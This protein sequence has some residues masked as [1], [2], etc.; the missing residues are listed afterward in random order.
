[1]GQRLTSML[2]QREAE[3]VQEVSIASS[4]AYK[5]PPKSG[6]Y[7]GSHFIMGGERFDSQPPE[8]FLFGEN[9][10]LNFLGNRPMPFPYHTSPQL[11]EPTRTL[12]SLVNIRKDTIRLVKVGELAESGAD[13]DVGAGGDDPT[14]T[15]PKFT[16]ED[17]NSESLSEDV[18]VES[19]GAA[20]APEDHS[21]YN[22]EF[23]FDSDVTCTISIMYFAKEEVVNGAAVYTPREA[24]MSSEPVAY[25][26][27]ASQLFT[28]TAHVL[29]PSSFTDDEWSYSVEREDIPI[30]IQCSVDNEPEHAGHSHI[31]FCVL[32]HLHD[33]YHI[34]PLKQKQCV[35]GLLYILQEFYGIENKESDQ[36]KAEED[37][38]FEDNTAECVICM[39]DIRDTLILPCRHLCLCN[40][41]ADSLRYQANNCPICR[42][43]FRAL[44]Q[45]RAIR[46]KV[47]KM[48]NDTATTGSD[49]ED[50]IAVS[51][52]GVP[53]G[54]EAISLIEALNGQCFY[55]NKSAEPI[56]TKVLTSTGSLRRSKKSKKTKSGKHGHKEKNKEKE[57]VTDEGKEKLEELFTKTD[58][59]SGD[60]DVVTEGGTPQADE[61]EAEA[62][63]KVKDSD[64]T[65]IP[66]CK[67]SDKV[68]VKA[69]NSER[70]G[71]SY[72]DDSEAL[73][74]S[75]NTQTSTL[76]G[77]PDY[78]L[79]EETM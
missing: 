32:E 13:V 79:D 67:K 15:K 38:E 26:R 66:D 17:T 33:G 42:A 61:G 6:N 48:E 14:S 20:S 24:A 30:I 75:C 49:E 56:P 28:Q 27:G 40:G 53:Q 69:K 22:I 74:V 23:I 71:S 31:T 51:Q 29:Q 11:N 12:R 43:P 39:S 4:N 52:K 41:C 59:D 73:N 57:D 77:T 5:W 47:S 37:E 72:S 9:S 35:D 45:L 3:G 7:F 68:P 55:N 50:D 34:R 16:G 58:D 25:K 65:G 8:A 21:K 1:M 78:V 70:T 62:M 10:D 60:K 64:I 36:H 76:P 63:K 46:R 2:P 19:G 54:F 44:L 18:D